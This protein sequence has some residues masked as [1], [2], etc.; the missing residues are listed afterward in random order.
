M[1][2]RS[3]IYEHKIGKLLR[4]DELISLKVDVIPE[5]FYL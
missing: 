2:S 1:Y 3:G 4:Y 5:I